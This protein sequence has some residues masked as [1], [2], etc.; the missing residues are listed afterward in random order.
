[1][2]SIRPPIPLVDAHCHLDLYPD[3]SAQVQDTER[4][5][6]YCIAV[7]NTPS[8]FPIMES[9]AA[10]CIFVLPALG[11]H[12][13]LASQ[14]FGELPLF[15]QYLPRTRFVG[16]IGLD[17]RTTDERD[18]AIQRRAF[19]R[20]LEDCDGAGNK[21][22]TIHSRRAADDVADAICSG[23]RVTVIL[24]WF[25]GS[26]RALARA[27]GCGAYLSVNREML[28]AERG[29]MLLTGVPRERVL[30]ETDGP[31]VKL[32]DRT[33]ATPATVLETITAL[34]RIWRTSEDDVRAQV[35]SNFEAALQLSNRPA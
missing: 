14:R 19:N 5:R 3:A 23:L 4:R 6:I 2:E 35:L 18:R 1:M 30:T 22:L 26:A 17:Y 32:P 24:H 15:A 20:I 29:R 13:E 28:S 33:P 7:T 34:T 10:G 16:E 12:P 31:F 21:V 8:V 27:L 11:L 9:L 25:S